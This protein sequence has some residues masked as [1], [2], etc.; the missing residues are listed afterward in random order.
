MQQFLIESL[1]PAEANLVE[2]IDGSK[3][4]YLSGRF[5]T[6]EER[7]G[8]GRI[9]RKNEI[10]KVVQESVEKIKSGYSI[11][12]ELNHPD[13][14]QI[15]LSNVSHSI[16]EMH[17]DGN[18]A[19]GKAKILNTPAGQIVKALLEGGVRLGVSSRGTGNVTSEGIV[20]DFSF[21]TIDVVANPSGPGCYPDLVRESLG[22]KKIMTLA[23]AV[24]QDKKAQKYFE[25]E[26]KKF[27]SQLLK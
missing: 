2:S 13:N 8:N 24:T 27:I 4:Y 18:Y 16:V 23:E 22:Q 20:E 11:L 19:V 10:E 3:N 6:A 9:Y 12:G 17:M 15:D 21:T 25:A 1:T 7:N 26:M 5:M 14:L